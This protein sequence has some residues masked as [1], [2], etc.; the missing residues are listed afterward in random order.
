MV[1]SPAYGLNRDELASVNTGEELSHGIIRQ[2]TRAILLALGDLCAPDR[3]G[4]VQSRRSSET[5]PR[6][7]ASRTYMG[8][9]VHFPPVGDCTRVEKMILLFPEMHTA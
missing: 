4:Q 6:S 8:A 3:E 1:S 5:V 7:D 2:Q 9:Y